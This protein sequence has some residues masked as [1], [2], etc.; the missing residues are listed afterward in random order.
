MSLTTATR[1]EIE[2]FYSAAMRAALEAQLYQ[3]ASIN[4]TKANTEQ[5]ARFQ[6][7]YDALVASLAP[8]AP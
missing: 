7:L 4:N 3:Q 5:V 2:A 6:A 8:L 1:P